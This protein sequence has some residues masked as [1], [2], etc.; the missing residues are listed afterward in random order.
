MTIKEMLQKANECLP[1]FRE[2]VNTPEIRM[3][4]GIKSFEDLQNVSNETLG[5]AGHKVWKMYKAFPVAFDLD[6]DNVVQG[7]LNG[8]LIMLKQIDN[9]DGM[10]NEQLGDAVKEKYKEITA[11]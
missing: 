9:I 10:T 11:E 4:F 2:E 8:L 5:S 7:T 1:L 6:V 3:L